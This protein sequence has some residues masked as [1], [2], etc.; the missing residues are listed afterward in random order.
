VG[1]YVNVPLE[2]TYMAAF[3]GIS[4]RTRD[5]LNASG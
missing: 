4:R 2:A 1:A 3:G 5:T